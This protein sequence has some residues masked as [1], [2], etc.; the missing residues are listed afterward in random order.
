MLFWAQKGSDPHSRAESEVLDGIAGEIAAAAGRVH[1]RVRGVGKKP[2]LCGGY[3]NL[4]IDRGFGGM[5]ALFGRVVRA[6]ILEH[7]IDGIFKAAPGFV[8]GFHALGG[9][10]ANFKAI[11][12]L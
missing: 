6:K 9:Q 10:L 8:G 3:K 11:H 4:V 2:G 12:S 7:V 1:D 5:P